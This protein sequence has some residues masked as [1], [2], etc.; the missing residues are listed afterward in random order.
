M[1][2]NRSAAHPSSKKN[3][4]PNRFPTRLS[5]SFSLPFSHGLSRR[6]EEPICISINIRGSRDVFTN[7]YARSGL[8]SQAGCVSPAWWRRRWLGLC[9]WVGLYLVVVENGERRWEWGLLCWFLLRSVELLGAV[10]WLPRR[11][12]YLNRGVEAGLSVLEDFSI[13]GPYGLSRLG[14]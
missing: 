2:P 12:G 6:R 10:L 13:L 3:S 11:S 5:A 14:W 7:Y 1:T 4:F 8:G 9:V